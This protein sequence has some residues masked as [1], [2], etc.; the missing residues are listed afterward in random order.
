MGPPIGC[1]CGS[2]W[3]SLGYPLGSHGV[4]V[5]CP[6]GA[7]L[8]VIRFPSL[9]SIG[10]PLYFPLDP[11]GIPIG[12]PCDSQWISIDLRLTPIAFGRWISMASLVVPIWFQTFPWD[13]HS[14]P[15]CFQIGS[16]FVTCGF[17]FAL[18]VEC[19]TFARWCCA[20]HG[21]HAVLPQSVPSIVAPST[22]LR[23]L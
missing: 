16:P 22:A 5:G 14:M 12:C 7:H 8:D 19:I 18:Q 15:N 9:I 20:P 11:H 10:F 6:C 4:A 13:P 1:P 23:D 21:V 3:V 2:R 17:R